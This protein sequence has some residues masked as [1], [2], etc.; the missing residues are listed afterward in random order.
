MKQNHQRALD[1]KA[2]DHLKELQAR[3][4]KHVKE[5]F[6]FKLVSTDNVFQ[7]KQRHQE[8]LQTLEVK[9]YKERMEHEDK[10]TELIDI[11]HL[12][13]LQETHAKELKKLTEAHKLTLHAI[14]N[15]H[16]QRLTS[17][18][19]TPS[20]SLIQRVYLNHFRWGESTLEGIVYDDKIDFDA[21]L[22]PSETPETKASINHILQAKEDL[23]E[24]K[25]KQFA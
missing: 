22:L 25:E 10:L 11:F 13:Q 2:A 4:M 7:V 9:H 18:Q 23:K 3:E 8:E 24:L 20:E 1:K 5:L 15:I 16:S 6:D 21:T 17:I 19:M 14:S 12:K